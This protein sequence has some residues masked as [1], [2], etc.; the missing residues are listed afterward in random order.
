MCDIGLYKYNWIDIFIVLELF[1]V[2][3]NA[4]QSVH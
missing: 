2:P 4:L 3:Y 1:N